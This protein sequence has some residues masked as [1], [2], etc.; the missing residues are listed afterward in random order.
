MKFGVDYR[1]IASPMISAESPYAGY[2]FESS[3]AV[4]TN[5][6]QLAIV[7]QQKSATPVF[8]EVAIFAQ[9]QWRVNSRLSLSSGVR[10]EI[11]PPPTEE[12]GDLPYTLL[13]SLGDPSKLQLAPQGTP[14]WHSSWFNFAPR[15]GAA[16]TVHD[17]PSFLTVVRAGGGV[18]FDSDNQLAV[19]GFSGVGFQAGKYIFNAS[20][21]IPPSELAFAPSATAPYTSDAVYAF[22]SHLQLPYTLEWNVSLEQ[23]LGSMQALTVAYVGS[24]G[25]RLTGTQEYSLSSQNPDFGTVFYFPNGITSNYQALQAKFQRSV[26]HG[27]QTLASYTWSHSLDFGSNGSELPLTRGNSDFDVRSNFQFGAAW[28]IPSNQTRLGKLL[29]SDWS[30][31]ARILARTGFPVTLGGNQVVDPGTGSIYT[32]GVDLVPNV[33]LYIHGALYP[34]GRIINKAAFTLPTGT[35]IG[36]APRN[37]VRGFGM[38]Q[39]N[40]AMRRNIHLTDQVSLLLRGEAFNI[41]NHPNFGLIDSTLTDATF[42]EATMMLNGSLA[43]ISSQYQQGGSRSLQLA[44]KLQF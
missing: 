34:G 33:P 17:L 11:D 3:T 2:I 14:L 12:H 10:W 16:W 8:H 24:S 23:A 20:V 25:R 29:L 26:A 38:A 28:D 9:D 1:H 31:D 4:A 40:F 21:P 5:S 35:N 36:T 43:T 7:I 6:A 18:F 30:A 41:L 37:F 32:G 22:P 19:R 44:L 27:I 39:M 15:F 13:G 42:G